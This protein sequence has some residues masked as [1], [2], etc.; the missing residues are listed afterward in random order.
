MFSAIINHEM[1]TYKRLEHLYVCKYKNKTQKLK[2]QVCA[3][4]M[5]NRTPNRLET[6]TPG[7]LESLDFLPLVQSHLSGVVPK[8]LQRYSLQRQR[9]MKLACGIIMIA[10]SSFWF[11][12]ISTS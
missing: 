10:L 5:E 11:M 3:Q 12:C 8:V 4:R 9:L 7:L 2:C 1:E 6:S